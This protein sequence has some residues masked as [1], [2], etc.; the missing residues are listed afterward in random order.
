MYTHRCGPGLAALTRQGRT[1]SKKCSYKAWLLSLRSTDPRP[2]HGQ[3]PVSQC[4][5]GYI[6]CENLV[7][8]WS[9]ESR[10]RRLD[11]WAHHTSHAKLEMTLSLLH[12]PDRSNKRSLLTLRCTSVFCSLLASLL[13]GCYRFLSEVLTAAQTSLE[14]ISQDTSLP[15]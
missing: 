1:C 3:S 4:Q 15:T 2:E 14:S 11:T 7:R 5:R 9:L 8:D 6:F 13:V 12:P 10:Q